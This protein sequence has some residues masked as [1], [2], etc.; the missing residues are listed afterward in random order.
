MVRRFYAM[1]EIKGSPTPPILIHENDAQ[2]YNENKYGIFQEVNSFSGPRV[3]ANLS[4]INYW[5]AE[6]DGGD[7]TKQIE[8][9]RRLPIYPTLVIESKNGLHVYFK[10][11]DASKDNYKQI[12]NGIGDF[13]GGDAQVRDLARILR[14]PNYYHWKDENDPFFVRTI[15]NIDVSYLEKEML[16]FFPTKEKDQDVFTLSK[17]QTSRY[18]VCDDDLSDFLNSLDHEYALKKLSGT[19]YVNS[20]VYSFVPVFGGKLNIFV[21]GKST[22]CFIDKDKKIGAVP[23]GPTVFQWL[24]YFGHSDKECYRII[25]ENIWI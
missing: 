3:I 25:K 14:A 20:E 24:R 22:N 11:R 16:Y 15:L 21:N 4:S 9:V 10:S 17:D 7:K 12:Q 23:G 19:K 5:Y 2:K 6:L 1:R 13:L 8:R 18:Y